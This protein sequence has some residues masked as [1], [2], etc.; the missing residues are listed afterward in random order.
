VEEKLVWGVVGKEKNDQKKAEQENPAGN[1]FMGQRM[2]RGIS[3]KT[4][5]GGGIGE[6]SNVKGR[7]K[8]WREGWVGVLV[9]FVLLQ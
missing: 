3:T 9:V 7:D 5:K 4:K 6:R 8:G 2:T 1:T